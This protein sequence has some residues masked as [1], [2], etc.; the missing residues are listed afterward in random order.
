MHIADNIKRRFG[1]D[2]A[3]AFSFAA[4]GTSVDGFYANLAALFDQ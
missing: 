4:Q 1:D 3:L 2:A